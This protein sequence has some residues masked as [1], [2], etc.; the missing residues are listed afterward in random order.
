MKTDPQE[1]MRAQKAA[2]V[3]VVLAMAVV[4]WG[5]VVPAG[6]QPEPL[7][8]LGIELVGQT[9]LLAGGPAA[10]RIVVTDHAKRKPAYLALVS[11]RLASQD[12]GY[13]ERLFVGRTDRYGTVEASFN[14]PD[15][16]PG[17]YELRV[18][19]RKDEHRDEATQTVTIKRGYQVL[20][21]TDKPIYQPGQLIHIRALALR[22]PTM[23]AVAD[24]QVILEA[25]DAKGNKV[26]KS[27]QTT[28]AYGV[29]SA[30]FQLADE[31][32]TGR[33]TIRVLLD[34]QQTEKKVTVERYVLPKFKIK[35]E[36]DKPYYLPGETAS[37]SV[38]VDYFFGQPVANADVEVSVKTFDV[39]LTEIAQI[40]GKTD[41][42]GHYEFEATLPASFVGQPIEQGNAYLQFDVKVTDPADH[43]EQVTT[44]AVVAAADLDIN[45]IPEAGR[46]IPG[47][48]NKVLFILSDPTGQ[49]VKG[50][51]RVVSAEAIQPGEVS[52][53]RQS[54][55]TDEM[56]IAEL[57][58]TYTPSKEL[59]E[60]L[61]ERQSWGW[62][63]D[64]DEAA[65]R[66]QVVAQAPDGSSVEKSIELTTDLS[67]P[68]NALLLRT[69]RALYAVGDELRAS[70]LTPT[71]RATVYFD[72][73]KDRQTMLT[74]AADIKDSRVEIAIPLTNELSGGVYLSA[75]R[76]MPHGDI[77]RDTR[78]L[79]IQPA[80][81]LQIGIKPDKDTY[82]PGTEANVEFAVTDTDGRPVQAAIGVNI[83]DE[84]VFALQ[85]LQPGM[86][87]VYFYLEKELMKPRYEIHGMEMPAIISGPPGPGPIVP[88]AEDVRKQQA[89]RIIFASVELPELPSFQVDS[90]AER[91]EKAREEWTEQM[92]PIVEH[93]QTAIRKYQEKHEEPPPADGG[94]EALIR[95]GF[96]NERELYDP[97]DR[98]MVVKAPPEMELMYWAI[99]GSLGP[100]GIRDTEDD[101][102][103]TTRW[104]Q[105]AWA[106][107]EDA[108]DMR[109]RLGRGDVVFALEAA[110]PRAL[111]APGGPVA[112]GLGGGPGIVERAPM[113]EG[114][115]ADKATVRV[116][117]EFP[118]TL[119]F[120][121]ALITDEAGKANLPI[122]SVKDSITT[123]RIGAM[124][125]S[126]AGQ[127]GSATGSLRVY[128]DFHIDLDLPVALTQN[129]QVSI[130]VAV[131]NFMN[132]PQRVRV[133]ME[134]GDWFTAKSSLEQ[135]LQIGVNEVKAVYFTIVADKIGVHPLKVY[136]LGTKMSDA[137][138]NVIRVEPDGKKIET[139]IS[140]RLSENVEHT[141]TIPEGA[142][143]DASNIFVKI[144]P[145]IF[146]QAVEGLD[147]ILRMPFG[148]FEQTTSVTYP[149][150]MVL[151]YM[152]STG[153]VS[154]EVQMKAEGFINTGYQ[155][156]V[157]YEV[158]SGGFSWF[159]EAPA[160]RVLTAY[161]LMAFYDMEAVH[162][163]DPAIISRTQQWL[164]D[165][166]NDDG[167]W[168]ADE[169]Y[170]HQESWKAIQ[171]GKLLPTAYIT[172]ALGW[173]QAEGEGLDKA[174]TYLHQHAKEAEDP[175]SLSILANALVCADNLLADGKLDDA[176]I[177]VLEALLEQAKRDGEKMWWESKI[178][179]LTHSSGKSADLEA[180]AT[181]ALAFIN[182]G[183]YPQVSSQILNYLI[184]SKDSRGT[185]HS[186][187]ATVLSLR[188]L[189]LAQKGATTKV[190]AEVQ[191]VVNGE[192]AWSQAITEENADLMFQVDCKQLVRTGD[193]KVEVKF[194]G[195][196]TTLYQIV[197]RYYMP[198]P[199]RVMLPLE[200]LDI[201][202][203]Y[204][205]TKLAVN[206][207]VTATATIKNNTP[208]RTSMVIVDLGVP[209]GFSV[210]ATDFTDL[211]DRKVIDKFKLTGRQVIVYL[212]KLEPHQTVT[213]SYA[214][215][216]RFP[217]KAK[218]PKSTVSEY[219]NP[220]NRSLKGGGSGRQDA[221]LRGP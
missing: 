204:D 92:R 157:S 105:M 135:E 100:D 103:M 193:N 117:T 165:Q 58:L 97:W 180:T 166:Q 26:F 17:Q 49:P 150:I 42:Q 69:D 68:G 51:V 52:L 175:Y 77:V 130:P 128:L 159:G 218:T 131:R 107:E 25:A 44:T 207:T 126:A 108:K 27:Q 90:Y 38:Q 40:E 3:I 168:D 163:V 140:D 141:V 89:A 120:E 136:G 208:A 147:S 145:G 122:A 217:I 66:L 37:G 109:R 16:E 137:V 202:V 8:P 161:G 104:P 167:S 19:A 64:E 54:A 139:A 203:G 123:F 56:G 45:A 196:G 198:W 191:V 18:R 212:E 74:R 99:V 221:C 183:R 156:M 35:L 24:R 216:A 93:I 20:L 205:K 195:E 86:E 158:S 219:Y 82:E 188:A 111:A 7:N 21:T 65:V 179:G 151:D 143:A 50:R 1:Q 36:T 220:D 115:V 81:E 174:V 197:G 149:N 184:A 96:L 192:R 119:L 160:N 91:L 88:L 173:T 29:A 11:I 2:I 85:D 10:L 194:A 153:Q 72:L 110:A 33:Y 98:R 178:T 12:G 177:G 87:K 70:V 124:A 31:V 206:D 213:F 127:L 5:V 187:M 215:T 23:Q 76:I 102:W 55:P 164:L 209:P 83:V 129:D 133:E 57:G 75:Y 146:S 79:Y 134:E 116:R 142:I 73:I 182:S 95:E 171:N 34:D 121:P 190:N 154:P 172:W 210:D 22:K 6:G 148:C 112:G 152:K 181:A 28:N 201:K 15:V 214:L 53:P 43:A 61:S 118:E 4:L 155:R 144:Y 169:S 47:L 63:P 199:K 176:T 186:T 94:V 170:L 30:D 59:L 78:P 46:I 125:N 189:L 132:Q 41:A 200:V 185:W 106:V 162:N 71:N 39:E 60:E 101:L 48:E 113:A 32:N 9:E 211:V 114:E 13:V 138:E 14:I 84:A 62:Q 80:S 67:A